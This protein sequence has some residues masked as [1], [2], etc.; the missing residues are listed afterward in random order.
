MLCA[1]AMCAQSIST[2]CALPGE[3]LTLSLTDVSGNVQSERWI[4][5]KLQQTASGIAIADDGKETI[6]IEDG[7]ITLDENSDLHGA[8]VAD[9]SLCLP[10]YYY[11]NG[12]GVQCVATVEG[13]DVTTPVEV[14][15]VHNYHRMKSGIVNGERVDLKI[16]KAAA[17]GMAPRVYIEDTDDLPAFRAYVTASGNSNG[18]GV[19]FHLMADLTVPADFADG[20]TFSGNFH[21]NGNVLSGNALLDVNNGNI[22]NLGMRGAPIAHANAG[23]LTNCYAYGAALIDEYGGDIVNCY[24]SAPVPAT[25]PE[26]VKSATDDE[27]RYGKVAYELNGYY[28]H[29]RTEVAPVSS[30]DQILAKPGIEIKPA[31]RQ[32]YVESL[33]RNG[34]YLY[35]RTNSDGSEYLRTDDANYGSR[36]SHHDTSHPVD[37]ARALYEAEELREYK[38]LFDSDPHDATALQNDYIFFGQQLGETA[39]STPSAIDGGANRVW[40]AYGF[41]HSSRHGFMTDNSDAGFYFNSDAWVHNPRLTAISLQ[42]A[43]PHDANVDVPTALSSFNVGGGVTRNLL[44][45]SNM[46]DNSAS[47]FADGVYD[48]DTPESAIAYHTIDSNGRIANLHLVERSDVS[49]PNNDLN[50]PI[51]FEVTAQAS[52]SRKPRRYAD[53]GSAAWEGICLPFTANKVTATMNGEVTHFYGADDTHHEYWLRGLVSASADGTTATFLRPG[54]GLFAD[55]ESIESYTFS[56]NWFVTAYGGNHYNAED[57]SWY[58]N[59][60]TY[61]GYRPLTAGIPYIVSFPGYGYYEFDLSSRFYNEKFALDEPQQTLTFSNIVTTTPVTIGVTDAM[62]LST[63]SDVCTHKATFAAVVDAPYTMNADGT[64][65]TA[66]AH[67]VLPFRTYMTATTTPSAIRISGEREL[68]HSRAAERFGHDDNAAASDA[69]TVYAEGNAIVVEAKGQTDLIVCTAAGTMARALRAYAGR[70]VYGGF[71]P[72]IYIIDGKKLSIAP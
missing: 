32:T 27:F 23:T 67:A 40:R 13:T 42:P 47:V 36:H 22:Y 24:T 52:Y 51:P 38:P 35:A 68:P 61:A 10:A 63:Q 54:D 19:D 46:E 66:E 58:A 2:T 30:G 39:T 28:I 5:G 71:R 17:Q 26:G 37:A 6:R 49:Q 60:H 4:I 21:G 65:F 41:M 43:T 64:A 33:Y 7:R 1:T 18:A 29:R 53:V 50:V 20:V 56:N 11:M 3:M 70:N 16:H 72:G 44:V 31:Y 15:A 45:Y 62:P 12:Y 69:F 34:D 8:C 14:L 57:N 59:T 55:G 25:A 48:A 9:G